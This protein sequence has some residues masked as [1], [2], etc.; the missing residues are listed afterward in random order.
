M[1]KLTL[2]A[3][4][5]A[6]LFALPALAQN[7]NQPTHP[8][9]SSSAQPM[10]SGDQQQLRQKITQDLKNDGYSD[11]QVVPDSFLVHAKNKQGEAVVMII[12]P[13]S[14]FAVTQL[15]TNQANAGNSNNGSTNKQ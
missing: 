1:Q 8:N 15:P 13:N 11:V 6:S 4:G 9:T 7:S 10:S 5:A 12:N 14:V 3:L 2:A